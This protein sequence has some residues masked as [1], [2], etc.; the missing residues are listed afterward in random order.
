[1]EVHVTLLR[2]HPGARM[3][4]GPGEYSPAVQADK[5]SLPCDDHSFLVVIHT[6][7][8]YKGCHPGYRLNSDS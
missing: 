8:H 7:H 6:L 3:A 2:W 1:M 4:I 5:T